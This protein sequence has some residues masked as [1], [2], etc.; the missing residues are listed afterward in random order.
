MMMSF[1][2]ITDDQSA[3]NAYT[4]T[5]N[6]GVSYIPKNKHTHTH[7]HRK[8]W[9]KWQKTERGKSLFVPMGQ[10]GSTVGTLLMS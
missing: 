5:S 10:S 4:T 7:I 2:Y 8:D 1:K 9:E 6:T 3:N